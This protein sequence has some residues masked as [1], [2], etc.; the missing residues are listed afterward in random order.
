M[1]KTTYTHQLLQKSS[2]HPKHTYIGILKSQ[3]IRFYRICSERQEFDHTCSVL[4]NA[5]GAQGYSKRFL[6]SIKSQT[7]LQL[8]T[9]KSL[10]HPFEYNP[11]VN[12]I[13]T[14]PCGLSPLCFT[15]DSLMPR[16]EIVSSRETKH[17]F[18]IQ[19]EMKCNSSNIIYIIECASCGIQY[20]G[21]TKRSLRH[22]FN[23]HRQDILHKR[24]TIVSL[25]FNQLQ[26][27]PND[28]K[29]APIFQCPKLT[30]AK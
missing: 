24:N 9:G 6:R 27:E 18:R 21:Q 25:H 23:N 30:S 5:L 11:N 20:I 15:C 7:W 22:R 4:F 17:T 13:S 16:S 8:E 19:T 26:G 3:I 10:N 12:N 2:F 1:F 14:A 29:I 28:C